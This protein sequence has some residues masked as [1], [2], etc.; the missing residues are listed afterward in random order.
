MMRDAVLRDLAELGNVAVCCA[1]DERT[2]VEMPVSQVIAVKSD[3]WAIWGDCIEQCDAV[4]PI[5]P[6]TG[7]IL[8]RLSELAL[9]R[10]KVLFGS[11]CEGIAL[12]ASKLAT[13]R[14]LLKAGIPSLHTV[15]AARL[16]DGT[17]G[18]WVAKPD[19][20][21]GCEGGFVFE[22][23]TACNAWLDEG[24]KAFVLQPY[25]E[26]TPAS[27]SMLCWEG[28]AWLLSCNR[29]KISIR[30]GGFLY[31]GSIVNGMADY[32]EDFEMLAHRIA[33]AIPSLGGYIGV[34]VIVNKEGIWVLEINPRLTTSYAGLHQAI[35]YNPTRLLIE[36]LYNQ[37]F[38]S[39]RFSM[40]ILKRDV[41]EVSVGG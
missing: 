23:A 37:R 11:S 27:L 9:E 14:V 10:G 31:E 15:Q 33:Q 18:R 30:E 7:G 26:G 17:P 12:T 34:D 32:W 36:L 39:A 21:V 24:R 16:H 25:T 6:E 19:D 3:P 5:A 2:P 40:P 8:H 41:V 35:G 38:K 13:Y 22:S 20:G 4:L 28:Q 29:Q 1:Y